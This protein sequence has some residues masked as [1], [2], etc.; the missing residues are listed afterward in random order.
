[1]FWVETAIVHDDGS[2]NVL[3]AGTDSRPFAK[4]QQMKQR[5]DRECVNSRFL[6]TITLL[7]D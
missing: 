2:K 1:M 3:W 6:M 7:W 5:Y 4:L